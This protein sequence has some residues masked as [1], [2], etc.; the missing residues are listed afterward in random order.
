MAQ[1]GRRHFDNDVRRGIFSFTEPPWR[2]LQHRLLT[3]HVDEVRAQRTRICSHVHVSDH[4][5]G[6]YIK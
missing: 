1:G 4:G 3:D 5:G 2:D 6:I